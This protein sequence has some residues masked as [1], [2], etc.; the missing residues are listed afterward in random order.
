M[1]HLSQI[2]QVFPLSSLI[3]LSK[4]SSQ[5]TFSGNLGKFIWINYLLVALVRY[6]LQWFQGE[7]ELIKSLEFT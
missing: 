3:L 4:G 5:N 1:T 2:S 7:Y 6:V